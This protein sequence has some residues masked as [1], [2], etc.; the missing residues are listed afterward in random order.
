[1]THASDELAWLG[2]LGRLKLAGGPIR[3]GWYRRGARF[4]YILEET[5]MRNI[6]RLVGILLVALALFALFVLFGGAGMMGFSGFN[7]RLG[8]I[9]PGMMSGYNLYGWIVPPAAWALL[10]GAIGLL[11]IRLER[12]PRRS[13][14]TTRVG[15]TPLDILKSRYAKSE[16]SK[17]QFSEMR[18]NLGG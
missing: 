13:S 5:K 11:L 1:M 16:I 7:T 10:I 14:T 2:W 3:A 17:E 6:G 18:K 4:V 9:G 15:G 12:G 8:M